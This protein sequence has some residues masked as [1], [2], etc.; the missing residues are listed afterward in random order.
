MIRPIEVVR[1]GATRLVRFLVGVTA[2]RT[3]PAR[4]RGEP[5]LGLETISM[6]LSSSLSSLSRYDAK[7]DAARGRLRADE[8]G[9][10][11]GCGRAGCDAR[12]EMEFRDRSASGSRLFGCGFAACGINGS[13]VRA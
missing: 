3:D 12:A 13:V 8:G 1:E 9:E 6:S 7:K 2:A 5:A 4:F 10:A 11:G